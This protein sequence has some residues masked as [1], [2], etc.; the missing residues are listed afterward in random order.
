MSEALP[1]MPAPPPPVRARPAAAVILWREGPEGREVFWVRR[2]ESLR[3]AGG[4]HAFPGGRVDE[5]D[6]RVP[7]PG[8]SGDD[9]AHVAAACRELFEEA[10]VLLAR[11]AERLPP[12]TRDEGRRALLDG[13][14]GFAELLFQEALALEPSLLAPAG[15]WVTPEA[16]PV[17]F[18]ARFFLARLPAGQEASVWPGEL[19]GGEFVPVR[20]A[21]ES[22]RR[23]DALLHPPNWWGIAA[24]ERAAPPQALALLRN[25]PSD[26]L[27]EFQGGVVLAALR[28]PTLLPATHTN[29]WIVDLAPGEGV[30]VVDPGASDPEEIARLDRVLG[31]LAAGGRPAREVWLTHH[32]VDHVGG[33]ATLA[34]RGLPVRAHPETARRLAG[35]ERFLPVADGDL[36]HGRWRALFTP[37]HAPGHLCFLDERSGALVAG[38]MVSTVST[39]VIDP[40]EGNMGLYLDS[41]ARLRGLPARTLYPAHGSPAPSAAAKLDEYLAHRQMRAAKV[42]A[43]LLPGGTLAEVTRVAYDDTPPVLLPVAERSCLATLLW[44]RENGR[45]HLSGDIWGRS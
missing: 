36:L 19:S 15:R 43:A 37:G 41:L 8:L 27:I 24:L 6:A 20:R 9:A 4:F 39:V 40:P 12:A 1:G 28:T 21:L 23:G 32:H 33:T 31:I 16:F 44:L 29:C 25:P 45:A 11:G 18:D 14:V 7:V 5:E 38:D 42:E 26:L 22:W 3:F 30:A 35:G 2:G 34:A 10:G 17:R 13:R